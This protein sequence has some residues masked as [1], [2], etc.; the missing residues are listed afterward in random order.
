M[1]PRST[2]PAG[3]RKAEY[4]KKAEGRKNLPLFHSWSAP[5]PSPG[6]GMA[7]ERP[8]WMTANSP[9]ESAT[10]LVGRADPARR[11][12]APNSIAHLRRIR[13]RS[14]CRERACPFRA[15][16]ATTWND[17]GRIRNT[18]ANSPD[19]FRKP[20]YCCAERR[21]R[22]SLQRGVCG[23]AGQKRRGKLTSPA[24][25]AWR[26]ARTARTPPRPQKTPST[27]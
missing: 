26:S 25:P 20:G 21:G 2:W 4:Y 22:R 9:G 11:A 27:W 6:G 8:I 16:A 3:N 24:A 19:V 13:T 12:A 17:V 1:T 23:C 7:R 5:N 18:L 14:P 15:A 10:L